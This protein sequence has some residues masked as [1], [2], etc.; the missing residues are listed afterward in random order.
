[1]RMEK[2]GSDPSL[3][4]QSDLKDQS[5]FKSS[6]DLDQTRKEPH[7]H[8][9]RTTSFAGHSAVPPPLP[10]RR[11]SDPSIPAFKF[12]SMPPLPS[13]DALHED[14]EYE[15]PPSLPDKRPKKSPTDVSTSK[16]SSVGTSSAGDGAPPVLPPRKVSQGI[17]PSYLRSTVVPQPAKTKPSVLNKPANPRNTVCARGLNETPEAPKPQ[18]RNM[19]ESDAYQH[20]QDNKPLVAPP[21][22]TR[23]KT[24][25]P[26]PPVM[27]RTKHNSSSSMN[28]ESS[29]L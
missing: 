14:I 5:K 19:S 1:M 11:P 8:V 26:K 24:N 20:P 2:P 18:P 7:D 29:D 25:S 17:S 15:T 9:K 22:P 23:P 21:I 10:K 13:H 28:S 3:H 4:K 16:K 27:P 6:G 12:P